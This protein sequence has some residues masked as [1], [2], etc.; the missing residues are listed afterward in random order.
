MDKIWYRNLSKSEVIGCCGGDKKNESTTQNRQK[1]NVKKKKK[2][3]ASHPVSCFLFCLSK[4]MVKTRK[5]HP[6][7]PVYKTTFKD[8]RTR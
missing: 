1:S 8:D 5:I 7:C 4:G 3:V 2:V 6:A